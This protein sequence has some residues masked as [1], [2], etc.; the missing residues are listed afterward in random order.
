MLVVASH[1][2]YRDIGVAIAFDR[3]AVRE[4]FKFARYVM[5]SSIL[6]I[7]LSQYDKVVLGAIQSKFARGLQHCRRDDWPDAG[8]YHA[9]CAR[10]ALCAVFQLFSLYDRANAARRYKENL[11]LFSVGAIPPAMLAGFGPLIVALLYDSRYMMAAEFL[12][13]WPL[14]G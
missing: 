3:E 12:P 7:V 14:E 1:F 4:Q 10:G 9:Q 13:C 2:F 8:Y 11:R 5:P 6:T